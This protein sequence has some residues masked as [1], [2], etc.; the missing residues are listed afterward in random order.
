MIKMIREGIIK[1]NGIGQGYDL[2]LTF[3]DILL[4]N[5]LEEAIAYTK[6][7]ENQ[8]VF[9]GLKKAYESVVKNK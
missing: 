3:G 5:S 1:K 6:N 8:N 4:G 7:E 9:I 2:P